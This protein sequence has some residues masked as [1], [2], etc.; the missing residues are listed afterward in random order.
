MKQ[1]HTA[2]AIDLP[3]CR[4]VQPKSVWFETQNTLGGGAIGVCYLDEPAN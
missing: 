3:S 4:V 1:R 2:V